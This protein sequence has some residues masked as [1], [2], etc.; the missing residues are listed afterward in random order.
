MLT[1]SAAALLQAANDAAGL[2]ADCIYCADH[3]LLPYRN[4]SARAFTSAGSSRVVTGVT[5]S[6]IG[7]TAV[8]LPGRRHMVSGIE[9]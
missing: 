1:R 6:T 8:V 4:A 7:V 3:V 2:G 9:P 5:P